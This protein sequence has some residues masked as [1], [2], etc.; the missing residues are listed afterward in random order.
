MRSSS[1][2]LL[3]LLVLSLGLMHPGASKYSSCTQLTRNWNPVKRWSRFDWNSITKLSLPSKCSCLEILNPILTS[4]HTIGRF[5][6]EVQTL[7][8]GSLIRNESTHFSSPSH[9]ASP[10]RLCSWKLILMI[11]SGITSSQRIWYL[12]LVEERERE[13]EQEVVMN[14][15]CWGAE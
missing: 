13:R 9:N 7:P 1:S 4:R 14:L 2:V 10:S 15:A 5:A 12:W 8:N 3:L 6:H 11:E